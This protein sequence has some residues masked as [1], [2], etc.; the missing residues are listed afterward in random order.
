S[1][2]VEKISILSLDMFGHDLV[3]RIDTSMLVDDS[4]SL[5]TPI[6]EPKPTIYIIGQGDHNLFLEK[7]ENT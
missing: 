5:A 4:H 6:L 1:F 2:L 7:Q 3:L